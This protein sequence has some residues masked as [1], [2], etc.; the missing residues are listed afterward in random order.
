MN[1]HL[2]E[3]LERTLGAVEEPSRGLKAVLAF[4]V[5]GLAIIVAAVYSHSPNLSH[6]DI[7]F[8]SGSERGNYYAVVSKLA[9][10]VKRQRGQIKNLPSAGSVENMARL[11][12]AKASCDIQFALVQD[13][14]PWP[15]R[16]PFE[17]VGRLS[18]PESFIVLGRDADRIRS[19]ADLRGMRIGIGPVGSG[20]EVV[21]RQVLAQLS[22]LDLEV[23]TQS[24]ESQLTMLERGELDLAAM[25]IDADA[26]LLVEAVR[27]RKLQIVDIAGADAL[28]HRLAFARA[29]RITASYYDA[30]RQL[31]PV[32]K[33]VIQVDALVI[34]N[35]C[36]R[37][38]VTQGVITAFVRVFPDFVRVNRESPNLTGL[39]TASAARSYYE[40]DG[41]DPVGA[42]VPWFIDIMPTARWLQAVFLISLVFGAQAAWHRFRLWRIDARRVDIES[43]VLRLFGHGVT[44]SEIESMAPEPRH[45][46][47]AARAML[48]KTIDELGELAERC[49]RQSVSLLVPM[50]QEMGYRIQEGLIADLVHALKRFRG[51]LPQ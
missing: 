11:A 49:R 8:L 33:R 38:S 37:E 6:V 48:Q 25:V 4:A 21:A 45:L 9:T 24:V 29:G 50:G 32:D 5:L 7:A 13:G 47:A 41:P 19:V 20:T 46:E 35:G 18:A 27:D 36:A 39:P 28:A 2:K 26:Q 51:R 12:A 40:N 1:D 30:V 42:Y 43:N 17:L 31:P 14:L 23:S 3:G 34:G 15:Q 22:G 16:N 10:E 44:V